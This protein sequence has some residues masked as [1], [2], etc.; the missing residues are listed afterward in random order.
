MIEKSPSDVDRD[1]PKVV[2]AYCE[3]W[4]V[5]AGQ[6]VRLMASSHEPCEASLAVVRI[7][8]GDPTRYGPGFSEHVV[9]GEL[10]ER[11]ILGHQPIDTGSFGSV[12]LVGLHAS[13]RI[14]IRLAVMLT[15]P[16]EPQTCLTLIGDGRRSTWWCWTGF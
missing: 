16:E 13:G 10:P 11:V 12:D 4:S 7:S 14:G 1:R 6:T 8:W 5:R 3:P 15:R 9:A 2:T